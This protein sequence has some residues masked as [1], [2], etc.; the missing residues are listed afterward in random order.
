[1]TVSNDAISMIVKVFDKQAL[2]LAP[3]G[4]SAVTVF[5]LRAKVSTGLLPGAEEVAEGPSEH[6]KGTLVEEVLN[7]MTFT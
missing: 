5:G 4:T 7:N 3:K 2:L 6:R 1:M